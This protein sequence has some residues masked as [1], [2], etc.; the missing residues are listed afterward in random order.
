MNTTPD[1]H[2]PAPHLNN[3]EKRHESGDGNT[4][5]IVIT[6]V[7][8]AISTPVVALVA[9]GTFVLMR[10]RDAGPPPDANPLAVQQESQPF[11]KRLESIGQKDIGEEPGTRTAGEPEQPRLEGLQL[12]KSSNPFV[13]PGRPRNEG[14]SPQVRPETLKPA[15]QLSLKE[16][17]PAVPPEPGYAR[18]PIEEAFNLIMDKKLLPSVEA[19]HEEGVPRIPSASNSGR[20]STTREK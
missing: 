16:Y 17:G 13:I 9:W 8:L 6:G 10:Q 14:N 3:G 12:Y 2:D 18:I 19:A 5:I 20:G 4:R 1:S 7:L 15:V 11:E